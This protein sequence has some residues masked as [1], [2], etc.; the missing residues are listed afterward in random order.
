[1]SRRASERS[2]TFLCDVVLLAQLIGRIVA[3]DSA[4]E[5][6]VAQET[7]RSIIAVHTEL[8]VNSPDPF[9]VRQFKAY[10][11]GL[12]DVRNLQDARIRVRHDVPIRVSTEL[13][14]W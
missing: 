1:M 4:G 5:V 14:D 13:L 9:V 12:E 3:D 2:S 10:A 7:S 6:S 8:Q 11:L